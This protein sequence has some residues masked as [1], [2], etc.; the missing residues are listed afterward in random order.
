LVLVKPYGLVGI[1][2]AAVLSG[3]ATTL[4]A[5]SAIVRELRV[6]P[7][8]L[9]R[10]MIP[11]VCTSLVVFA[12]LRALDW[13]LV[14]LVSAPAVRLVVMGVAASV[15]ALGSFRV[16]LSADRRKTISAYVSQDVPRFVRA[17]ANILGLQPGKA[18]SIKQRSI[19]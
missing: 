17:T 16:S 11:G 6:R 7:L 13:C 5:F 1:A 15:V 18:P 4:I 2:A 3:V 19:G 12:V 8:D 14:A 9:A 10:W